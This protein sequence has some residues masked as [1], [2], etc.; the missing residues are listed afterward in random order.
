MEFNITKSSFSEALSLICAITPDRS[1]RPILQNFKLVLNPDRS[2]VLSA[3]DLEIG[4][5]LSLR[6]EKA[7]GEGSVLLPATRLNNLIKGSVTK[8]ISFKIDENQAEI[9]TDKG[10][11]HIPGQETTDYP[12]IPDFK[13]NGS[14]LMHGDEFSDAVQKTVFAAAKGD[15]RY[16]LNG[17]FMNL[18]EEEIEF[19]ASDTHRLSY[20]KKKIRNPDKVKSDGIIIIKGMTTLARLATSTDVIKIRLGDNELMAKTENAVLFVRRVEG[21]FPRYRDVIPAISDSKVSVNREELMNSLNSVGILSPEETHRVVMGLSAKQ[22]FL[23]GNS[24]FGEGKI[25][26]EAELEGPELEVKFN[27]LFL[28]DALKNMSTEKISLQYKDAGSP[29]RIDDGDFM[30]V[31]MPI[32]S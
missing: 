16:A 29:V 9:R 25:H 13:E 12:I 14:F 6:A 20:I 32:N 1:V 22:V 19:V 3:T 31:I 21:I 5:S 15:T 11:F 28:I 17:I 2:L 8:E 10:R 7:E 27:Y 30:Y 4:L 24:D 18:F 26:L 23:S